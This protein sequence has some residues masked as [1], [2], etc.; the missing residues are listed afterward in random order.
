[1][2]AANDVEEHIAFEAAAA[3]A[4]RIAPDHPPAQEPK[5]VTT[6]VG[7]DVAMAHD[8][9]PSMRS[10]ATNQ[11]HTRSASTDGRMPATHDRMPFTHDRMP[12][13]HD[14][15]PFTHERM[16]T[17]PAPVGVHQVHVPSAPTDQVQSR[18]AAS[19]YPPPAPRM[20]VDHA[21]AGHGAA[22]HVAQH[23]AAGA[24]GSTRAARA[25]RA[26][27]MAMAG[28]PGAKRVVARRGGKP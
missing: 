24:C 2:V 4:A 23:A 21:A 15:I 9:S 5:G 27:A 26:M 12:F 11:A 14:S 17:A 22:G 10:A 13:T 25:A 8:D 19:A 7:P 28:G 1:M 16:H 6:A 18:P 3:E 20:S